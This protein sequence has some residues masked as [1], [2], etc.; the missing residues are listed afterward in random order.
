MRTIFAVQLAWMYTLVVYSLM[1]FLEGLVIAHFSLII[2]ARIRM[3]F[4]DLYPARLNYRLL[5]SF[6]S[7]NFFKK[8]DGKGCSTIE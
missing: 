7:C 6:C 3:A 1:F 4:N 5:P 2:C 8:K